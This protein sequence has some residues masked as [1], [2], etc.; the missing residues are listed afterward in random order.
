MRLNL[1]SAGLAEF[2]D[3]LE[4]CGLM[5]SS[6]RYAA[7]GAS[8]A[9]YEWTANMSPPLSQTSDAK[10]RISLNVRHGE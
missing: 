1:P 4:L 10:S 5:V 6:V 9:L 7:R 2:G 8:G 3:P